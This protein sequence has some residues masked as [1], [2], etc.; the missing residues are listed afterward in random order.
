VR[1]VL[2]PAQDARAHQ[3]PQTL[4]KDVRG[5]ALLGA[6]EEFAEVAAVAEHAVPAGQE[7]PRVPDDLEGEVDGA[8][9]AVL[10]GHAAPFVVGVCD[11][12]GTDCSLRSPARTLGPADCES[13]PVESRDGATDRGDEAARPGQE[14]HAWAS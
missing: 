10:V 7:G 1:G 5:D 8:A 2:L 9:G 12:A 13:Q 4:G 14:R 6:R 3:A 11:A